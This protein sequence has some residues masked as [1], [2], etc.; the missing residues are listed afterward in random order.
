MKIYNEL[1]SQFRDRD[2]RHGYIDSFVDAGIATQIK[3]LREQRGITQAQLAAAAGMKQSQVCRL[4]N[5]NNSSWQVRT[6][7]RIAEAFDVALVVKFEAFGAVLDDIETFGRTALQRPS[8]VDDPAFKQEVD[9]LS[10]K[11]LT[12][13]FNVEGEAEMDVFVPQEGL[14]G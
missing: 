14:V 6:L 5:S 2:F 3:V 12:A 11:Q 10:I 13:M 9:T 1:V 8:F 7:K 4:E